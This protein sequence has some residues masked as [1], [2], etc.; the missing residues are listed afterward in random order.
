[1]SVYQKV[2]DVQKVLMSKS[3]KTMD[4]DDLLPILS[5]ECYKRELMFYFTFVEDTA[6]L[7]I[8]E[9]DS[10]LGEINARLYYE[11]VLNLTSQTSNS[12]LDSL[13]MQLLRNTFLIT[14]NASS[15]D[16]PIK[17]TTAVPPRPIRDAEEHIRKRGV[18]VTKESIQNYLR[19]YNPI[20]DMD[21]DTKKQVLTYLKEMKK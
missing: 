6:I 1:M 4:L 17:E 8:K 2:A 7:K 9:W 13:K 16:I 11:N 3:F 18:P 10:K 5:D 12:Q 21:Q 15:A 19:R 20:K 14:S